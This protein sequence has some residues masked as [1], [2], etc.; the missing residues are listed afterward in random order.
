MIKK[1]FFLNAIM[2]KQYF[3]CRSLCFHSGQGLH[4]NPTEFS[5]TVSKDLSTSST[6][7]FG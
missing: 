1:N 6:T 7:E 4:K 3:K 2:H 5:F